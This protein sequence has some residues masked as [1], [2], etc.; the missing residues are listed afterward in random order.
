MSKPEQPC[1]IE[2]E[3]KGIL[4]QSHLSYT[5]GLTPAFTRLFRR[6]CELPE[7]LEDTYVRVRED[8]EL[9]I[10]SA[11]CSLG[12]EVDSLLALVN[13][14]GE[15]RR[16]VIRGWDYNDRALQAA[17]AGRYLAPIA[18]FTGQDREVDELE[19]VLEEYEFS[20]NIAPHN[21]PGTMRKSRRSYEIDAGQVRRA[22]DVAFEHCDLSEAAPP[23]E[24]ADLITANNMLYHLTVKKAG[25]VIRN[26]A[27]RLAE[28]GVLS[29]GTNPTAA[30]SPM[31]N[32]GGDYSGVT[33][34]E[35]L[36]AISRALQA[37][38]GIQPIAYDARELPVRFARS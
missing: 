4:P 32:E 37:E 11:G 6:E 36:V 18:L 16:V 35:W 9:R 24:P 5:Q 30:H 26:L 31:R 13:K 1:P 20:H 2:V 7:A 15:N 22:H 10:F 3:A 8:K 38:F 12:A 27:G 14:K 23:E 29:V 25:R 21:R 34:G 17:R 33:H 28:H 19:N